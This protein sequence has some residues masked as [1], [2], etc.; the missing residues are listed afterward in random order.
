MVCHP[1]VVTSSA[2]MTNLFVVGRK[3][4]SAMMVVVV[5]VSAVFDQESCSVFVLFI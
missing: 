1:S 2:R 3:I 5:V 4:A